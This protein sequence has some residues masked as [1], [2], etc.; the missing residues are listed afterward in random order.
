[1][2]TILDPVQIFKLKE[3]ESIFYR[4]CIQKIL[5]AEKVQVLDYMKGKVFFH[6]RELLRYV[7]VLKT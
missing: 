3:R 6:M 2:A 7:I 4:C 5:R 1:M